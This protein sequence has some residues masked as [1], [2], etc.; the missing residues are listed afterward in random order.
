MEL[1]RITL[2]LLDDEGPAANV[3]G[4]IQILGYRL[5]LGGLRCRFLLTHAYFRHSIMPKAGPGPV[6]A[7][8]LPQSAQYRAVADPKERSGSAHRGTWCCRTDTP[9]R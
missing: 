3:R 5:R 6:S 9:P 8:N 1:S 2:R 4:F 7:A